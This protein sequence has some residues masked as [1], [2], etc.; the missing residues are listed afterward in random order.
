MQVLQVVINQ[1]H[2]EYVGFCSIFFI[3]SQ[4]QGKFPNFAMIHLT[5]EPQ[6]L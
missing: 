2:Q 3:L 6:A 4:N 5:G 1:F